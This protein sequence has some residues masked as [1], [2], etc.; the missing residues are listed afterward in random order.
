MTH[1]LHK[2][3][4]VVLLVLLWSTAVW[5]TQITT[6]SFQVPNVHGYPGTT[7]SVRFFYTGCTGSNFLDS[8]NNVIMCGVVGSNVGFYKEV[9]VTISSGTI[10]IPAFTLPSTDNAS[11]PTVRVT[12]IFY[13]KNGVKRDALFTNWVIPSTLGSSISF[14]QLLTYNQGV[15]L[16]NPSSVYLSQAAV[17]A[18]IL[19]TTQ[20]IYEE[21]PAGAVDG[22][23]QTFT[24]SRIPVVG[25]DLVFLDGVKQLRVAAPG[26]AG[27]ESY[28]INGATITHYLP[29]Q[30]GSV[31]SVNYR[32]ASGLVGTNIAT[33][34]QESSGPTVLT[35]GSWVDGLF[36]KRVGNTI[37]GAAVGGAGSDA[38]TTVK[39]VVKLTVA[40]V[41]ATNPIAAGDNDPRLAPATTTNRGT[42]TTTTSSSVVASTDD[43]R[44]SLPSDPAKNYVL[45]FSGIGR[46]VDFG[47]FWPDDGVSLG[48]MFW[49]AWVKPNAG[50][51]YIISDGYGG[52]H[53]VLF[54]TDASGTSPMLITGNVWNGTSGI[55]FGSIDGP[56]I[57]EWALLGVSWDGTWLTS[58]YNGVPAGSVAFAGPR[59]TFSSAGGGGIL[60][61][62]GSDHQNF[63][64]YMSQVRGWEGVNPLT[65]FTDGAATIPQPYRPETIFGAHRLQLVPGVKASF[66]A[67]FTK[68]ATQIFDILGGHIGKVVNLSHGQGTESYPAPQFILDTT[69]PTYD[70]I[71]GPTAPAELIPTA[72]AT[73]PG[74][75]VFDSFSRANR[76]YAFDY[77]R[78]IGTATMTTGT[79]IVNAASGNFTSADL[80]STITLSGYLS[81][82][83]IAINSTTQVQTQDLNSLSSIS[84]DAQ[85]KQDGGLGKTEAGSAGVQAWRIGSPFTASYGPGNF[86]ILN[87]R[88][89]DLVG[90]PALAWIPEAGTADMEVTVDRRLGTYIAGINTGLALRVQD[91]NNFL[92]ACTTGNSATSTI[93]RLGTVIAGVKTEI[94]T[95]AMPVTWTTLRVTSVGDTIRAYAD[96]G[97][98]GWVAVGGPQTISSFN[99]AHGAG[100]WNN[101]AVSGMPT[102]YDNFTVK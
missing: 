33:Q 74:A 54:G 63:L 17:A 30:V 14:A 51:Q 81:T 57:G 84:A 5:A 49:E 89:A 53:A 59:K 60:Y 55:S 100:L 97:V 6:S 26:T 64:G 82:R 25:S 58:Y 22:V 48:L 65:P 72:P 43:P 16:S 93:L 45:N 80:G 1:R 39:G 75:R 92:W 13:D 44:L 67:T 19:Q 9:T 95:T 102:R 37:V 76:T 68:P 29:P 46:S 71:T 35:V 87:G 3:L 20:S 47:L 99:T 85:V 31:L 52:A 101:Y 27:T 28:S 40:P 83:I 10:T 11:K 32:V 38:S 8:D 50:G 96:D 41:S 15:V 66:L 4:G 23:N 2:L 78:N 12:A 24:L 88:V 73:P 86:G 69:A 91:Q 56:A 42:V 18:L 61:I 34:L 70:S 7:A 62:G 21:I 94:L 98:G 79:D 77:T 36:A 90:R